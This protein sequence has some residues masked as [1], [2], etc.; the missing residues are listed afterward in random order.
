MA[1]EQIVKLK[2]VQKA[3]RKSQIA[4]LILVVSAFVGTALI[5]NPDNK[6][7]FGV[8]AILIGI[9]LFFFMITFTMIDLNSGRKMRHH[10]TYYSSS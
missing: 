10:E 4:F 1:K 9:P 8:L 5:D 3:A 2:A 7:A 6:T